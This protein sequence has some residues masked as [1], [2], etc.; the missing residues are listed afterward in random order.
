[1]LMMTEH[2]E[3]DTG[4]TATV[5]QSKYHVRYSTSNKAIAPL[6][7]KSSTGI[8]GVRPLARKIIWDVSKFDDWIVFFT[9]IVFVAS[10]GC[11]EV[12]DSLSEE[13]L[14]ITA[15][16]EG[17]QPVDERGRDENAEK[18]ENATKTSGEV[19][20][21]SGK[22]SSKKADNPVEG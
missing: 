13:K 1:M 14:G 4:V 21:V 10:R 16:E 20:S 9:T 17:D 3:A 18:T 6:H 2:T 15:I 22:A 11:I 5:Q 19:D 12:M 7:T 8:K